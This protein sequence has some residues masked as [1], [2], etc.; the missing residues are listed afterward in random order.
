MVPVAYIMLFSKNLTKP[1]RQHF[2]GDIPGKLPKPPQSWPHAYGA[3]VVLI[4]DIWCI[5]SWPRQQTFSR[6]TD[7]WRTHWKNLRPA[8]FTSLWETTTPKQIWSSRPRTP[9][10]RWGTP[11]HLFPPKEIQPEHSHIFH[12]QK[13]YNLFFPFRIIFFFFFG[14][15]PVRWSQCVLRSGASLSP[16]IQSLLQQTVPNPS[17]QGGEHLIWGRVPHDKMARIPRLWCDVPV[18]DWHW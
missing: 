7:G 8:L 13:T 12:P 17:N 4:Y 16:S 2:P 9:L 3:Q 1:I 14:V 11:C 10:G 15:Q 18:G 5:L 6:D